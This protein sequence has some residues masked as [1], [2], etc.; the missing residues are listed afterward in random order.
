MLFIFQVITLIKQFE[1]AT[2]FVEQALKTLVATSFEAVCKKWN[3]LNFLSRLQASKSK[4]S[5]LFLEFLGS[6]LFLT[7]KG[8]N[9]T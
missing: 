6:K 5:T 1:N 8:Q 4:R 2:A 7:D 9:N 3:F